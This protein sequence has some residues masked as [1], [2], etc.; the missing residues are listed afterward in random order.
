MVSGIVLAFCPAGVTVK[1]GRA[2]KTSDAVKEI[3][4]VPTLTGEVDEMEIAAEGPVVL[5]RT[6]VTAIWET[7]PSAARN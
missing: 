6:V 4:I 3:W 1:S 2:L 5:R 7:L